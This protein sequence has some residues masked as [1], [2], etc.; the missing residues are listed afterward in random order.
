MVSLFEH[1]VVTSS[2]QTTFELGARV[3]TCLMPGACLAL[4]GD[5]GAG[6]TTFV[7]G[8]AKGLGVAGP[9]NS[10]S[11]L[12]VQEYEGKIPLIHVD[13]YR[14]HDASELIDIGF[15]EYLQAGGV[16]AV[17]W[18]QRVAEALPAHSHWI[19]FEVQKDRSRLVR[20]G[21]EAVPG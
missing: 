6:K 21:R 15:D 20:F 18:G 16:V 8:L 19:S 5:L 2:A 14:L 10:P 13:A 12:I 4:V 11:Y 3:A 1:P 9:V 7:Q 17:E